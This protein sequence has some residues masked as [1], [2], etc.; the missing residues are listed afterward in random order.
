MSRVASRLKWGAAQLLWGERASAARAWDGAKPDRRPLGSDALWY[1]TRPYQDIPEN[2]AY[3]SVERY[4]FYIAMPDGCRIAVTLYLPGDIKAE[5]RLPTLVNQTCYWRGFS[6]QS[7]IDRL[8]TGDPFYVRWIVRRGYAYMMVDTRGTGASTGTR[9]MSFSPEEIA[10]TDTIVDWILEQPWS[11][12]RVGME[13]VSYMGIS[14]YLA[15]SRH[16]PGIVAAMSKF[17]LLDVYTD[18]MYPGGIF[19][20]RLM[21]SWSELTSAL[22][23]NSPIGTRRYTLERIG[24]GVRP[25]SSPEGARLLKEAVDQ[26]S[27]GRTYEIAR[28]ADF[29]DSIVPELAERGKLPTVEAFNPAN[30]SD[31]VQ[32]SGK[33]LYSLGGWYDGGFIGGTINRFLRHDNPDHK[34]TIGPW[35]H[36]AGQNI[37][38]W[39][40][41]R[42]PASSRFFEFFRFFDYH[43]KGRDTGIYDEPRVHYFTIGEEK[44]KASDTWPPPKF[45]HR[46]LFLI[47]GRGLA[48]VAEKAQGSDKYKVDFDAT[49]GRFG[50]WH[51]IN[52][53]GNPHQESDDIG[54]PD[55]RRQLSRLMVYRSVPLAEDL[56]VTGHALAHLFVTSSADDGAFHVYLDDQSADGAV[57]YVTEGL[58]RASRRAVRPVTRAEAGSCHS[59]RRA[60]YKPLAPGTV[61]ELVVEMLPTSYLFRRGHVICLSLAGADVDNFERIPAS[62]PAPIIDVRRGRAY[63]SCLSLPTNRGL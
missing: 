19:A 35:D 20:E 12:R 6:V 41:S 38:P 33:A 13:G 11:N 3:H 29:R 47:S 55:R 18:I 52:N 26:R 22:D 42:R 43:L 34:L 15:L 21:R 4:D 63:P 28:A 45:K 2:R 53:V 39:S 32:S 31:L 7:P 24:V 9:A 40:N 62:G 49:S 17:A 25:V 50:R 61:A 14:A 54:Y 58:L 37:S 16:H 51:T 44:W 60:D 23:R 5:D 30:Y 57:S 8:I 10:D 56:E 36:G 46:K 59:Y 27:N 48:S 1:D